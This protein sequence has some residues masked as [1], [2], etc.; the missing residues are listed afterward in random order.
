MRI[1]IVG[2][3]HDHVW[4]LMEQWEDVGNAE[5]VGIAEP[6]PDLHAKV[7]LARSKPRFFTSDTEM[8]DTLALDAVMVTTDNVDAVGVVER[9]AARGLSIMLE[10]PLAATMDAASQVY[11]AG[12]AGKGVFFVNWFTLWEP[13]IW[14]A[15]SMAKDGAIGRIQYFRF[16]IG[17]AG[18]KEIGCTPEFYNWLYDPARNGG[19]AMV[20]FCGYGASMAVWLLGEPQ[21]VQGMGG[22]YLK[23]DIASEDN[24]VI[25]LSYPQAMAVCEGSWTQLSQTEVE[26]PV[27]H[28]ES[29]SLIAVDG[30]VR[31]ISRLGRA[32][33]PVVLLPRPPE[34][35]SGPAFFADCVARGAQPEGLFDPWNALVAQKCIAA[36]LVSAAQDGQALPRD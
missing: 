23:T 13:A 22:R 11:K 14:T 3:V 12:R 16:R 7:A 28:G 2:L 25:V 30:A 29:G 17:H 6:N 1:G 33:E 5:I 18:P 26:G 27:I 36:G 34:H 9:A 32:A 35:R 10:K 8:L 20:D 21:T 31:M 15:L 4:R 24:G 19:G